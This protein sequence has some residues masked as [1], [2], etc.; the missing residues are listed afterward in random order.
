MLCSFQ[1]ES[2]P[3]AVDDATKV[4]KEALVEPAAANVKKLEEDHHDAL[5]L[6]HKLHLLL[7]QLQYQ[8]QSQQRSLNNQKKILIEHL[9]VSCNQYILSLQYFIDDSKPFINNFNDFSSFAYQ[10]IVLSDQKQKSIT[11]IYLICAK[12]L[13]LSLYYEFFNNN[14]LRTN[15]QTMG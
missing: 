2:M 1:E 7:K 11:S 8:K 14:Y 12:P 13:L 4:V 10:L 3:Q 5:P 9:Y 6:L 15:I